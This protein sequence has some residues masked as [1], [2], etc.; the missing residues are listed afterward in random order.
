MN[1]YYKK[2]QR[3]VDDILTYPPDAIVSIGGRKVFVCRGCGTLR[4]LDD[5]S[6]VQA[7]HP[8]MIRAACN[9]QN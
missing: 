4:F 8:S 9:D 2:F 6:H 7:P 5:A 1:D 3:K